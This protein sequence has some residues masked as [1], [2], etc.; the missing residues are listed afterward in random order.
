MDETGFSMGTAPLTEE[1][2]RKIYNDQGV[3]EISETHNDIFKNFCNTK[4]IS[5]ALRFGLC[6]QV[7]FDNNNISTE[8]VPWTGEM[9]Q[10]IE[11]LT[12]ILTIYDTQVLSK[13]I[14]QSRS[15]TDKCVFEFLMHFGTSK[16]PKRTRSS[17]TYYFPGRPAS[18]RSATPSFQ[19]VLA[20]Q[21]S[22]TGLTLRSHARFA[23]PLALCARP[24]SSLASRQL[25]TSRL[26]FALYGGQRRSYIS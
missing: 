17:T 23:S 18:V 14:S 8:I 5:T 24:V 6:K 7:L 26:L 25:G 10:R 13:M 22:H 2:T 15:V 3:D 4:M 9:L 1:I 19:S 21:H 11:A 12:N 16:S 20:T